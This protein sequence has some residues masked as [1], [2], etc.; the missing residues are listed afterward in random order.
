M[1]AQ[2]KPGELDPEINPVIVEHN[3]MAAK[4]MNEE[5][6]PINDLGGLMKGHLDLAQGTASTRKGKAPR[7]VKQVSETLLKTLDERAKK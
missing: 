3:A 1:T 5:G 6:L 4:V 2:N 7:W